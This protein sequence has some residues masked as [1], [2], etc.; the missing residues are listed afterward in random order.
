MAKETKGLYFKRK[1]FG[2]APWAL[3]VT[4][5]DLDL[6]DSFH[7]PLWL[8]V[9]PL[10]GTGEGSNTLPQDLWLSSRSPG[11]NG[12]ATARKQIGSALPTGR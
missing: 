7:L 3:L 1:L 2:G 11:P 9:Y 4:W 12:A 6:S 5:E 10:L 8:H